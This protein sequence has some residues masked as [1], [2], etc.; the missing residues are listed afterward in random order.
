MRMI[1][2]TTTTALLSLLGACAT[3]ASP[4]IRPVER[5]TAI[6]PLNPDQLMERGLYDRAV[7][8][9]KAQL[10]SKPDDAGARFGLA[11][12]LRKSGKLKD[13]GAEYTKLL[14]IPEW[15]L[16]A[17]EGIGETRLGSGDNDGAREAFT[18]VVA[19]DTKAWKSWLGLAQLHDFA[20]EWAQA[21]EA[22]ANALASTDRPALIYNNQGLSHLARGE[23]KWASDHFRLALVTDPSLTRAQTN[24]EIAEAANGASLEKLKASDRDAKERARK[25]NNA[26]Y[27]AMLQDRPEEARAFYQAAIEEHPSFYP[28]AFQN[29]QT[30]ESA[31]R[32]A[33]TPA[34]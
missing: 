32:A 9:Y 24:L 27:V 10:D 12:A 25:L 20:K 21:D 7:A 13:A 31:M 29:L 16:R 17:L 14:E 26:G 2:F 4:D 19:E 28:L 22:Y 18:N 15:K 11:E 30:L 6:S 34:Q 1:L 33:Q 3:T 5:M 8:V 23:A